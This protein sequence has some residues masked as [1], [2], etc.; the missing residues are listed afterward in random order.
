GRVLEVL[1][2]AEGEER[3]SAVERRR[4]LCGGGIFREILLRPQGGDA[5]QLRQQRLGSE[6]LYGWFVPP[7]RLIISD[8]LGDGIAHAGRVR[9]MFENGSQLRAIFVF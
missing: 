6:L 2:G 5:I 7:P 8:F 3:S 1:I 9:G 4:K